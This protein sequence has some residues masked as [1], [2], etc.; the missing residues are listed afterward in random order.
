MSDDSSEKRRASTGSPLPPRFGLNLGAGTNPMDR[1]GFTIN[2][3]VD[4][5]LNG[6]G[7]LRTA[8]SDY[9][10]TGPN[11]PLPFRPGVF[12]DVHAV[13]PYGF[14][15]VSAETTRVL[16]PGGQL[17]VSGNMTN[18]KFAKNSGA[19]AVAPESVGLTPMA[20]GPGIPPEHAFGTQTLTNQ[21]QALQTDRH[22]WATYQKAPI[23]PL[24]ASASS[25][26]VATATA[27]VTAA[28][29]T[30]PLSPMPSPAH[31]SGSGSGSGSE[32]GSS[33]STAP[34]Y[35]GPNSSFAANLRA[36]FSRKG[37]LF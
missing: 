19:A 3:D 18:N 7:D 11:Q 26:L 30:P 33:G 6:R 16:A 5:S 2:L 9:V 27:P 14:N 37:G 12:D 1:W 21:R 34:T 36:A 35:G 13:N 31:G 10:L 24:S 17:M 25:P 15:P 22:G 32:S 23:P 8:H 29:P 4:Q 28:L 20:R